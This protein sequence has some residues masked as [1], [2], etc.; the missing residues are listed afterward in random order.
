[1]SRNV[2]RVTTAVCMN[3]MKRYC[4]LYAPI[5]HFQLSYMLC[6]DVTYIITHT[7]PTVHRHDLY[8]LL[9]QSCRTEATYF[10]AHFH[11]LLPI[12]LQ[13]LSL[14]LS[15]KLYTLLFLPLSLQ[16]QYIYHSLAAT[17]V[18]AQATLLKI[19][20]GLMLLT[21]LHCSLPSAPTV[22]STAH[23]R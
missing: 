17:P 5:K 14:S 9:T 22:A 10:H 1:M 7:L 2:T 8:A 20:Q 3:C 18:P 15:T 16:R 12:S 13:L 19:A 21:S 4:D 23:R 6:T 11:S